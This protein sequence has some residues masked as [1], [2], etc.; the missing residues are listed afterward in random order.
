[1]VEGLI[2]LKF[3][4]SRKGVWWSRNMCKEKS[5]KLSLKRITVAKP[6]PGFKKALKALKG[7]KYQQKIK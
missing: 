6:K 5:P 1:M 7:K 2:F 4:T 3:I